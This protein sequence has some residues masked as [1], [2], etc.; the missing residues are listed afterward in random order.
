MR[1]FKSSKQRPKKP[2]RE[3]T[4]KD[5]VK[6]TVAIARGKKGKERAPGKGKAPRKEK[7]PPEAGAEPGWVDAGNGYRLGLRDG[8][9]VCRNSRGQTLASVPKEVRDGEIGEQ[10]A[11]V[12]EWLVTHDREC[13]AA[14]ETWMLRSLPTPRA[15]LQEIWADPSWR[16]ALENTVVMPVDSGGGA[17]VEGAGFF[18]GVDP[19]RG[20]GL[21][22]LDGETVWTDAG[23]VAVPHPTLLGELDDFRSLSVELSLKQGISQLFREIFRKSRDLDPQATS[24]TD[25]RNGKFAQLNH[26]LGLCRRL[27]YRVRGGSATTR[28]WESGKVCEARFWIGADDPMMETH[29][30][31]LLWVDERDRTLKLGD[32]GPV[33]F[34]EGMRMA[35]SIYASRVVP[36]EGDDV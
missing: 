5:R 9:L 35:S 14:V 18:R 19:A 27:G 15:V 7:K 17:D 11:A 12:A 30:D 33:A 6:K 3:K 1:R 29:T 10:L 34:S 8:K 13:C 2:V 36:K 24:V 23:S 22:T 25:F 4:K 31:A 26:A 20:V 21:V 32:V 16:T 28:V